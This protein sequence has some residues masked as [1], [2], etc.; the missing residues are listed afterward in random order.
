MDNIYISERRLEIANR[1]REA[2]S[3]AGFT[4]AKAAELIGCSR[5]HFS[6]VEQGTKDLTGIELEILARGFG[7]PVTYF[8][9]RLEDYPNASPIRRSI[10]RQPT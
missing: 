9:R 1:I 3:R 5:V 6:R 2:R 4:Q 10:E 7:V 8:F